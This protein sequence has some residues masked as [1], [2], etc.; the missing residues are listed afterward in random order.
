MDIYQDIQYF[1]PELVLGITILVVIIADLVTSLDKKLV[2]PL[3]SIIGLIISIYFSIQLLDIPDRMIFGNMLIID[4]FSIFFRIFFA[5]STVI[6]ILISLPTFKKS[7]E[8]YALLISATLGMYLMAASVHIAMIILALEMVGLCCYILAGYRKYELRSSEAALKYMLYGAV[9]TGVMLYGFSFLY[10]ITNQTDLYAI[11]EALR[12]SNVDSFVLMISVLFILA[13]LGYKIAMVPF[14]FWCPDVYE[15]A[16]TPITTFFSVGPKVAG[17]ALLA[18]FIYAGLS[19]QIGVTAESWASLNE[20]DLPFLLAVLSAIT[21]TIGNFS[22]LAQKNMKRMLAYS[23]IAHAGYIL[24]GFAIFTGQGL[25]AILFYA[26]V[27]MFMNFGAF[28]VVDALAHKIKSEELEDYRGISKR[29]PFLCFAMVVFLL[30]LTGLPPT[31]GF[32]GKFMIF[33]SLING[34]LYWLAIIGALN[35]VVSLYY[36]FRVAKA[37]YLKDAKDTEAEPIQSSAIHLVVITLLLIPTIIFGIFWSPLVTL[38]SF[39]FN[40]VFPV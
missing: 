35:S 24:M 3:L 19:S 39:G 8:Y 17:V 15:G 11:G 12:A 34:K 5:F 28:A 30:S 16:P 4:K 32:I 1:Y 13:G 36:Y 10:G 20:L 2:N 18:R 29:A 7:G 25:T 26:I 21:M 40:F 23:S 22:A 38:T 6:I 31:A 33:A 9:S 37:M 27:Y 14:H